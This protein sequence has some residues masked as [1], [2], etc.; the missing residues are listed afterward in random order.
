M[1]KLNLKY[2]EMPLL[3]LNTSRFKIKL[4]WREKND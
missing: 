4:I 2:E 1:N 3:G